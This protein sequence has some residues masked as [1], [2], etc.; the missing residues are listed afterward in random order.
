M[1]ITV[2]IYNNSNGNG[3]LCRAYS[4]RKER[5]EETLHLTGE[6]QTVENGKIHVDG[7]QHKLNGDE[8]GHQIAAR[9]KT[10]DADEEQHRT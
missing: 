6:K 1:E 2:N 5:K 3:R 7:I 8:H 9:H 4:N 10:E